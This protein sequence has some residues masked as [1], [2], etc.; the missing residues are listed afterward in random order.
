[1]RALQS[2]LSLLWVLI[3]A[4]PSVPVSAA[5]LAVVID[6]VGYNRARGQRAVRLP[7][8]VTIAVLPF[9]PHTPML[10]D[11]A[12]RYGKD[13]IVHQP[14]EPEPSG[15]ARKEH[16]TLTLAMSSEQFDRTLLRALAAVPQGVG[17]SNH[18]GSLLTR[19]RAPMLRL[20]GHLRKHG[21][22]FLDSRTTAATV[23]YEIA[24]EVGVPAVHRDVFL[25]HVR[26]PA[27]V[28]QAFER[29]I[30]IARRSGSAVLI[31]H[32]YPVTLDYLD[33][34]LHRLPSD[35]R[36]VGLQAVALR[37]RTAP[38]LAQDQ[39]SLRISLGQ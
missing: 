17:L 37:R 21:L 34:R 3:F 33:E 15:H 11:Q 20:M 22:L 1:M 4:W 36:L 10:V 25:D 18:T 30:C 27:A 12:T 38:V 39:G 8:P 14:M 29:A 19:H 16:D 13:I 31:G 7:G 35:V 9:A 23:A 32:P 2:C 5:D 26:T 6:D 28:H 24:N